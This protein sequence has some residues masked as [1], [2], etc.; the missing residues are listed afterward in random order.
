MLFDEERHDFKIVKKYLLEVLYYEFKSDTYYDLK[1]EVNNYL[2][3]FS[4]IGIYELKTEIVMK[5]EKYNNFNYSILNIFVSVTALGISLTNLLSPQT[6]VNKIKI[7]RWLYDI[8]SQFPIS[9]YDLYF[10]SPLFFSIIVNIAL[11]YNSKCKRYKMGFK[12]L[13]ECFNNY[14]KEKEI[15]K[16]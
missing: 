3:K 6:D 8:T 1:G 7:F 4:E 15:Q 2:N 12:F 9:D 13:D 5:M 11:D 10:I 14:F 16:N